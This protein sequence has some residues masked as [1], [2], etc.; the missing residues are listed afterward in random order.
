MKR[1]A[2]TEAKKCG[3]R[4]CD[5]Y[6]FEVFDAKGLR[7]GVLCEVI[8]TASNDIWVV[9]YGGRETLVPALKSVVRLVDAATKKIVVCLPEGF[10]EIFGDGVQNAEDVEYDGYRIYED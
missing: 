9:K 10:E 4:V 7:L 1:P 8:N 2:K 3:W 6:G 5:I